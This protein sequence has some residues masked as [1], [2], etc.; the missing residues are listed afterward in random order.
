MYLLLKEKIS[1]ND[2]SEAQKKLN[3]F[4]QQYEDLY[5]KHT[6]TMNLHLIGHMPTN[7]THLGPSWGVSAYGFESK[8]GRVVKSNTSTKDMT[9]QL[10]YKYIMQHTVNAEEFEEKTREEAPLRKR[11]ILKLDMI[12]IQMYEQS[13]FSVGDFLTIHTEFFSRGI[14]Y[15]S[16]NSKETSRI[17]YF[18]KSKSGMLCAVEYYVTFDSIF[19]AVVEI[20]NVSETYDH[21]IEVTRTHKKEII[22][23]NE[24]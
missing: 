4:Q 12:E 22:Q 11:K 2:I 16:L 1:P 5:G 14:L 23:A 3:D 13:G 6:V 10:V 15:K 19:Y 18:I 9:F 17:D 8:N 24:I 7:V 21:L 20:Y